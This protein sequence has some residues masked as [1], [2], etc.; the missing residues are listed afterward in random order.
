MNSNL[1]LLNLRHVIC[2]QA[3]YHDCGMFV[4]QYA[5]SRSEIQ[6]WT[7]DWGFSQGDMENLRK[8]VFKEFVKNQ[9]L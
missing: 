7:G 1:L 3:N 5:K 6:N 8:V 2:R 4:L 9:L